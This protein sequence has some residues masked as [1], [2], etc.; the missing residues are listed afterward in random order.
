MEVFVEVGVWVG[1]GLGSVTR[2]GVSRLSR[3]G[4]RLCQQTMSGRRVIE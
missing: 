1:M 2:I 4:A 3:S